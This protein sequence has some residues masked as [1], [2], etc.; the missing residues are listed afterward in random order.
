MSDFQ[1]ES[2]TADGSNALEDIL[3]CPCPPKN[4][5]SSYRI[6]RLQAG[7]P[8]VCLPICFSV[9]DVII[10]LLHQVYSY[11]DITGN[12]VWIMFFDFSSAYNIVRPSVMRNK[13][14]DMAVYIY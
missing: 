6:W 1:P 5:P 3:S 4:S 11:L 14:M 10:Y 7:S 9:E 13:L 8:A 2:E 12:K